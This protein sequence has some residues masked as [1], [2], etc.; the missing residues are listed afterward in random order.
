MRVPRTPDIAY[1]GHGFNGQS[2]SRIAS[3]VADAKQPDLPEAGLEQ[4]VNR[5]AEPDLAYRMLIDA[6]RGLSDE[7]SADLNARLIL[8]LTNQIGDLGL[9]EQALALARP[10]AD[11]A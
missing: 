8:I 10:D 1:D 2:G 5:C 11:K 9:L 3:A 6:H 7:A 4:A